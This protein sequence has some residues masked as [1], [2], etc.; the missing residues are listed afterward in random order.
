M[1]RMMMLTVAVL[2]TLGWTGC[3]GEDK[4]AEELSK[5]ELVARANAICGS[6][7]TGIRA[8]RQPAGSGE[9][10]DMAAYLDRSVPIVQ[11]LTD[12]L[13]DLRPAKDVKDE[14][15]AFVDRT[16]DVNEQL[17]AIRERAA[18]P[19]ADGVGDLEPTSNEAFAAAA[20]KLGAKVC[21][22]L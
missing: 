20:R 12:R 14:W 11:R 10:D 21:A 9:P 13:A 18:G 17:K 5:R 1:N 4:D 6:A 22:T 16:Q 19:D 3:G 15:D 7:L 2:A 8:I